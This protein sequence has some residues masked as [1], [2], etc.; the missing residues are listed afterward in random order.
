MIA[1]CGGVEPDQGRGTFRLPE[2]GGKADTA[3]S[4]NGFCGGQAPGGCWC[5][6]QCALYGDCCP[7]KAT[8]CDTQSG[9][10]TDADCAADQFCKLG[11]G[12]C[13]LP[14]L[15]TTGT[16]AVRPE[17]CTMQYDPVCGCDGKTYSN[18]CMAAHSGANVA[19]KG[20]CQQPQSCESL[21]LQQ[22]AARA[23]CAVIPGFCYHYCQPSDPGCCKPDRCGDAV[24]QEGELCS[25][26][27][28]AAGL[29]CCYPCGI[30]GCQ[31]VCMKPCTGPQ[32]PGGCPMYP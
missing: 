6:D 9:C 22:C 8:A 19:T 21:D 10:K 16:C 18:A 32:C 13:L 25:G 3:Y 14:T 28:C 5:D 12:Q 20:A 1:A 11:D 23:D 29:V 31:N 4:C 30:A 2:G 7:D 15:S 27:T 26:R 24:A 17:V